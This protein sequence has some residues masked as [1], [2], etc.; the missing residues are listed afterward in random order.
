MDRTAELL[1]PQETRAGGGVCFSS[2]NLHHR[3]GR[4]RNLHCNVCGLFGKFVVKAPVVNWWLIG[5]AVVILPAVIY[6]A[7]GRRG[8]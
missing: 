1:P 6:L 4:S 7:V 8:G 2:D 3:Q 5:A